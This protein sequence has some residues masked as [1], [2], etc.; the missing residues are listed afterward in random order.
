MS[1]TVIHI[2]IKPHQGK[3]WR[4]AQQAQRKYFNFLLD[5]WARE[6]LHEHMGPFKI[7][8]LDE[9]FDLSGRENY[10]LKSEEEKES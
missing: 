9:W 5:R 10:R 4:Q 1:S 8:K 2:L 6:D 3:K 7:L